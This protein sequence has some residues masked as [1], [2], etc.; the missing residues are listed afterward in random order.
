MTTV[1]KF[2]HRHVNCTAS[3][4]SIVPVSNVPRCDGFHLVQLRPTD[5]SCANRF[6]IRS[7]SI[8]NK[9]PSYIVNSSS[10]VTFK[11]NLYSYFYRQQ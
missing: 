8:W 1:Y 3:D 7:A 6:N 5:L 10:L 2:I 9:L 4:A 11:S